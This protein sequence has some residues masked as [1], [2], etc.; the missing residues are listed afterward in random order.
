MQFIST[1]GHSL[2]QTHR[3]LERMDAMLDAA[4]MISEYANTTAVGRSGVLSYRNPTL[5]MPGVWVAAS[6]M[7]CQ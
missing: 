1:V 7:S 3:P 4:D 6:C 2:M 5:K